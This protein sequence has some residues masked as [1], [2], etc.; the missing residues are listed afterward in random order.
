L[1]DKFNYR[2]V[3]C[4]QKMA[5][6]K[7]LSHFHLTGAVGLEPTARGFGDTLRLEMVCKNFAVLSHL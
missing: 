6:T 3:F 5:Q 7:R 1:L 4:I 2:V